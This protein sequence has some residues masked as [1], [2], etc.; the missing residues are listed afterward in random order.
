MWLARS[1]TGQSKVSKVKAARS[2]TG[3]CKVH[4]MIEQI[5]QFFGPGS[6]WY[7]MLVDR[8]GAAVADGMR[9]AMIQQIVAGA[10][11]REIAALLVREFGVG[12]TWALR[13]VRTSLLH[14]RREAELAFYQANSHV[15]RGWVWHAHFDGRVCI[16]CVVMH[17]T[18]HT[19]DEHLIDHYNGRCAMVPITI[20]WS[21]LGVVGLEEPPAVQPGSAWFAGLSEAEQQ[22]LMGPSMWRAWQDGAISWEQMSQVRSD[23]VY[24]DMRGSPSL[25]DLLGDGAG[26]Y[27]GG[28]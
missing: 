5:L 27:Y 25:R 13:M 14:A 24:G 6:A 10:G 9:Q 26:A 16:S 19:V 4:V 17:G 3:Q 18:R 22:R 23:P 11:P 21:D 20:P 12:L 1:E 28:N 8:F 2:E 15:I 7:A